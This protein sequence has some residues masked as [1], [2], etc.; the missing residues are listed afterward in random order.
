MTK[1][2]TA[3]KTDRPWKASGSGTA[4]RTPG[5]PVTI[6]ADGQGTATHLG[7]STFHN[8]VVCS[9]PDCLN[10]T[11]SITIVAANGDKVTASGLIVNRVNVATITG[12][13]GRFAGATGSFTVTTTNVLPDPSNQLKVTFDF[14]QT[15]TIRY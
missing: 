15:G 1:T 7:K 4:T 9:S 2:V 10:A 5:S 12:G 11:S 3:N 13:T 8:D 14:S 6:S